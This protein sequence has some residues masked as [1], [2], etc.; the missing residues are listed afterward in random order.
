[1]TE[2]PRP[3]M[4]RTRDALR[5]RDDRIADEP[6]EDDAP[7]AESEDEKDEPDES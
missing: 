5:Q 7:A 4:D 2:R 1:M 3:D 6:D